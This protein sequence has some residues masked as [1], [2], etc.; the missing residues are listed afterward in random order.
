M[1]CEEFEQ[2]IFLYVND[3]LED[4]E[5]VRVEQHV[6]ACADCAAALAREQRWLDTLAARA[7]EE[8][9]PALL[10]QCRSELAEAIDDISLTGWRRW[11]ELL[12]PT[13]W[14]V[15][16][17]AVSAVA[18]VLL[19][20]IAGNV[21]PS[22][23]MR[24]AGQ[25]STPV[26]TVSGL[27]DHD[28]RNVDVSGL[29][30][31]PGSDPTAPAVELQMTAPKPFTLRGTATDSDV[32]QVLLSVVRDSARSDAGLRLESV[33]VLRLQ[34][35]DP[36]VRQVLAFA[37]RNDPNPG[38]RLKALESLRAFA[39][40]PQVRQALLDALMRDDNPGVRV[41]AINTLRVLCGSG[42]QPDR[43]LVEV[44]KDRMRKDPSTYV[45]LQSAA[46]IRDLGPRVTY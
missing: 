11:V 23:L 29:T 5:R 14:I 37:A 27:S 34:D 26:V 31:V 43:Q 18:L 12:R 20:I 21:I 1:Q 42:A 28:L 10:A 46:A 7:S 30:W 25:E 8:P 3:E 24:D 35:Q 2:L 6:G 15:L 22:W 38:V 36:E 45:R 44:L 19:G 40:D 33:D 32:R 13:R 4:S 17:P 39:R 9:A 41:E 16:R